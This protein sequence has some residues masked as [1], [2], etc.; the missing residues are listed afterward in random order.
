MIRMLIAD[1]EYLARERI[2]QMLAKEADVEIV[3]EAAD[4]VEAVETIRRH[5]PKL[6]FL[7]VQMPKLD[8][9]GVLKGLETQERPPA[10]IFVTAY[11][12]FAVTA[13]E[14]N[15]VDY[16]LKPLVV[17]RFDTALHRARERLAGN[18]INH[19]VEALLRSIE[20][21]ASRVE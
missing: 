9:F 13:F 2:R 4:G 3:A 8:G 11:D 12:R 20:K 18:R 10:I 5:R 16:L 17:D 15:A 21:R 14:V 6:L 19:D 7:D 1:D